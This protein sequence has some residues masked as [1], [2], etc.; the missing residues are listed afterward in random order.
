MST[1]VSVMDEDSWDART[2]NIAV[3]EPAR[4]R[5]LWIPRDLWCPRLD[6]RINRAFAIG[7]GHELLIASLREHG[8]HVD[9]SVCIRRGATA[10]ALKY[11]SVWVPVE[12]PMKFWY[13]LWPLVSTEEARK[14]VEFHPP[15]ETLT[16][17][18][19][20]QWLGARKSLDGDQSDLQRLERHKI[21][22]SALITGSFDFSKLLNDR[23][24][25]SIHGTGAMEDLR[26]VRADWKQKTLG[27]LVHAKVRQMQVV[28]KKSRLH[29]LYLLRDAY[30]Y[31][32]AAFERRRSRRDAL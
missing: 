6:N 25:I 16:G 31:G 3:V 15:G 30:R 32:R 11:E 13:P 9:A 23:D 21:F 2:D 18:R 24:R 7:G 14:I 8:I 28:V 19:I 26:Q 1:V 4:K 17:E 27:P 10:R 12:R 29:P 20:H 5:I 22:I